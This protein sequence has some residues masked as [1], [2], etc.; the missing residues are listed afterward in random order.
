MS[1][2]PDT[3]DGLRLAATLHEGDPAGA[4]PGPVREAYEDRAPDDERAFLRQVAP[5]LRRAPDLAAFDGPP[6]ARALLAARH[7]GAAVSPTP[8]RG[9]RPPPGLLSALERMS[10]APRDDA[11]AA[12]RGR[13]R[14]WL[15]RVRRAVGSAPWIDAALEEAGAEEAAAVL[16]LARLESTG[17]VAD[18]AEAKRALRAI[19]AARPRDFIA[20]LGAALTGVAARGRW[21]RAG[22]E[23]REVLDAC[24]G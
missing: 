9:Y 11:D 5:R 7:G 19:R 16:A 24:R 3:L 17:E 20:A 10:H 22:R 21:A 2:A 23:V 6:R 15:A 8:R 1:W 14:A 18:G 12:A 13:G 4:L